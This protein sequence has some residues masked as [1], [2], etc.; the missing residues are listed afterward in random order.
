MTT[1]E[2]L[3]PTCPCHGSPD[4]REH[5]FTLSTAPKKILAP[6]PELEASIQDTVMRQKYLTPKIIAKILAERRES[7]EIIVVKE[8]QS[9]ADL[10]EHPTFGFCQDNGTRILRD[11]SGELYFEEE[12]S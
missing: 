12:K 8:G 5:V 2:I 7:G 9:V 4:C 1:P 11:P 6:N 3:D 10:I